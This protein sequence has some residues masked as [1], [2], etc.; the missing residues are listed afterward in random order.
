M[1]HTVREQTM[2]RTRGNRRQKVLATMAIVALSLA[3]TGV[4]TAGAA[5]KASARGTSTGTGAVAHAKSADG[6]YEWFLNGGDEGQIT[7]N[8]DHTWTAASLGDHGSWLV[9]GST[10]AV[11]D[12][13]GAGG[14][15]MAKVQK[16]GLST[17]K[18]PGPY[19]FTGGTSGTWYAV[20]L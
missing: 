5:G 8:S 18:K 10:I 19:L 2:V 1:A 20:K 7:L 4:S 11:S 13:T 12:V 17:A 14:T 15:L 6:T 3:T 9:S 16:H